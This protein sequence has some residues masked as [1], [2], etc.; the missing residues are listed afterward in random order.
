M[1]VVWGWGGTVTFKEAGQV[2]MEHSI[3]SEKAIW[4]YAWDQLANDNCYLEA[5]RLYIKN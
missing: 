5:V 2:G 3:G 4:M 1:C